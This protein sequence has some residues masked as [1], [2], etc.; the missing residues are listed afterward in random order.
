MGKGRSFLKTPQPEEVAVFYQHF[1]V[2]K[3]LQVK[4]KEADLRFG[5][6]TENRRDMPNQ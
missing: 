2:V 4:S 3:L 5:V 6:T 1:P